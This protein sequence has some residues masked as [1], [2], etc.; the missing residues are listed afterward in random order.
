MQ[1]ARTLIQIFRMLDG[2]IVEE[3]NEGG[4]LLDSAQKDSR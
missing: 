4:G 1:V 2:R 3:W